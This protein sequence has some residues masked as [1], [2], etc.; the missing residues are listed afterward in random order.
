M[1]RRSL[2]ASSEGIRIAKQAFERKGWT[3]DYLARQSG[4]QTRQPIWKFFSGKP[5]DRHIF[6]EICFQ[7]GLE[8]EEIVELPPQS[9]ETLSGNSLI[10]HNLLEDLVQKAHQHRYERV[11]EQCGTLH[12]LDV[13]RPIGTGEL[14]VQVNI[15]EEINS[16]RWLPIAELQ[17]SSLSEFDRLSLGEWRQVG[18]P[19]LEAVQKYSKLMVLGKPGSGKTTFLQHLAI[20][21]NQ[22]E[23][24][25]RTLPIF[26]PLK[27][28][29]ED[30]ADQGDFSLINYLNQEYALA[31]ISS[32]E[33]EALLTNGKMLLLLDGLD[34][35]PEEQSN[36][37]IRQIRKFADRFY[38]NQII[39]TCRLAAQEYRF[40]GFTEV[41]IADFN[42]FQVEAFA[43]NWFVSVGR[44]EAESGLEQANLFLEEL[45]LP[46]NRQIRDLAV[47]PL[48]LNLT[49]LVFQSQGKLGNQR[50]DLYEHGLNLLLV[51][52]DET[53]GIQRDEIYRN[54]SLP[55]KLDMLSQIAAITF[56]QK[57][58][59]FPE[60]RIKHLISEYLRSLP[61]DG[62][63]SLA[64]SY[65][66]E[67]IL[68][69]IESQHG[70]LVERA[71]NIY[72]FSHLTFQ[73]YFTARA[74]CRKQTSTSIAA[75][76]GW[77]DLLSL[78][79]LARQLT[80][81]HWREVIVLTAKMLP[82]G[83]QFL[84]LL[85]EEADL[86]IQEDEKLQ[87]LLRWASKKAL[88]VT[89]NYH[90]S[91]VRAFYLTLALP[92]SHPLSCNHTLAVA[93]DHNLAGELGGDLGLD[94]A[95]TNALNLTM[96]MTPTLVKSRMRALHMA[97]ELQHFGIEQSNLQTSLKNL[98]Q[99]L[100]TIT[101]EGEKMKQWWET[102]GETWS[103]Q[104]TETVQNER[105]MGH[106][107]HLNPRQQE[108]LKQY[109]YGY[110]VL[111]DC[112][113]NNCAISPEA[114][115]NFV[116]N[117]FLCHDS[118]MEIPQ[119]QGNGKVTLE[120]LN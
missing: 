45:N 112:L 67:A 58:Y 120:S 77:R 106:N 35:V 21:C 37:V 4:I 3:Q 80:E 32:A 30:G 26:I 33:V 48:L 5:V 47:T 56:E 41:E 81:K 73:E 18:V 105:H 24:Q 89:S 115:E 15:L 23:S 87:A 10:N 101:L 25:N 6:A 44:N 100:P 71:R 104:L 82:D 64:L 103:Q 111:V 119:W 69:A 65:D 85:K 72:S 36:E 93:I 70:L 49:C 27:S 102:Q 108:V 51:R 1:A 13:A 62:F 54:L 63:D 74:I 55:H 34:E 46:E 31:G 9:P 99:Q 61:Q 53:R 75:D 22:S 107:W 96:T 28:L 12:L 59:F 94:L 42:H 50:S 116:D 76:M 39:I 16:R 19:G 52:W 11:Q 2:R 114:Q 78:Q 66:S 91:A 90:Q 14:F 97:L 68:K 109:C 29:A 117:L 95:L 110:R 86:L 84:Q 43:R 83:S 17:S 88:T 20:Q 118:G 92:P 79:K 7:L 60:S 57:E 8:F 40:P 113:N 98:K 38:K